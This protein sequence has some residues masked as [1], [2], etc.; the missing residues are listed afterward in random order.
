[1][2]D[3]DGSFFGCSFPHIFLASF[4]ELEPVKSTQSYIPKVF[5]F[6]LK[7]KKGSVFKG[8]EVP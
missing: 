3:V 8:Q 6:K 1:M 5:G 7:H 2:N 4:P